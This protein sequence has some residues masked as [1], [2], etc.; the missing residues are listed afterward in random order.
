MF[1]TPVEVLLH[2]F[3]LFLFTRSS[4]VMTFSADGG[5]V[6]DH[7]KCMHNICAFTWG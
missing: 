6:M 5:F 7:N 2:G 4:A 3:A 1:L